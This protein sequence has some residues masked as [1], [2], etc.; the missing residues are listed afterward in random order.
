MD[1]YPY[2]VF[3]HY[4]TGPANLLKQ[5]RSYWEYGWD[6]AQKEQQ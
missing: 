5:R 2:Q 3:N 6:S 1:E 4:D